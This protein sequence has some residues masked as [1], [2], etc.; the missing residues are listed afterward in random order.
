MNRQ[1]F[2]ELT[3]WQ[4]NEYLRMLLDSDPFLS[5]I[6]VKGE[7]SNFKYYPSSG[8]MYF[9]LKDEEAVLKSV[10][11]KSYAS[12]LKFM[13]KNGMKVVARGRIS[14]YPRD[15]VYQLYVSAMK[16]DGKGNLYE[17][18]E[19][20]KVK[21]NAEGLFAE[22]HKR[23]LPKYPKTIGI[24]TSSKGAAL[25]DM[26]NVLKRRNPTVNAVIYPASVQGEGAWKELTAGIEY[27]SQ[28]GCVD[29]I[30]IGRGGGAYEDLWEF[31]NEA[32]ARAIYNCSVPVISA[33]GHETDFTI[34][35]FVAD[36]RA[37]TPSA[38]A[39]LAVPM[40]D[41]IK[42]KLD[43][44][45]NR[46][47]IYVDNLIKYKK[48]LLEG[49]EKRCVLGGE[50]L[51]SSKKKDIETAEKRIRG[52]LSIYIERQSMLLSGKITAI[53]ALN[54][55]SVLARGYSYAEIE[56]TGEALRSYKQVE[57]GDL[58]NI[59]L[60]DGHITALVEKTDGVER[61]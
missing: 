46:M 58:I 6:S 60:S 35:D 12:A 51:I 32:L 45:K 10:M 55:L 8:H 37:P 22:E 9:S 3:V 40:L 53:E 14:A 52:S 7:I 59:K 19:R 43:G 27:F 57:K 5:D 17:A 54:P 33:V 20:L 21:L 4:V 13:P 42:E 61:I 28:A 47:S 50:H 44:Y 23:P 39:E 41:E 16:E 24:V 15:G 38:A 31:N 30:I 25:R 56:A 2:K 1:D 11:F 49:Y 36:L 48:S 18:L 26:L 29:I 34:C